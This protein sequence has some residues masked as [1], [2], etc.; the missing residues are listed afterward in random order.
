LINRKI[1]YVRVGESIIGC[2]IFWEMRKFKEMDRGVKKIR[3]VAQLIRIRHN[4][5]ERGTIN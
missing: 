5:L 2:Q 1:E 3:Q 4:Y